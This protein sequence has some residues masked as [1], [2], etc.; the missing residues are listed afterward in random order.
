MAGH[1]DVI[2][3]P[4]FILGWFYIATYPMFILEWFNTMV[5]SKDYKFFPVATT[6]KIL[7]VT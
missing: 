4:M 3:Y 6:T 5:L 2:L 7:Y 1:K